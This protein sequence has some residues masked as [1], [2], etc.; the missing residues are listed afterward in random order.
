MWRSVCILWWLGLHSKYKLK[1][2]KERAEWLAAVLC[3]AH[4]LSVSSK[5]TRCVSKMLNTA[6]SMCVWGKRYSEQCR[7]HKEPHW[8][9]WGILIIIPLIIFYCYYFGFIP[10][11]LTVRAWHLP[12]FCRLN[13]VSCDSTKSHLF[14]NLLLSLLQQPNAGC[15]VIHNL[16]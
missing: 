3:S 10:W 16:C 14:C 2:F 7:I 15:K 13:G 1:R 6:I 8:T 12:V 4:N 11:Y 9:S 5:V